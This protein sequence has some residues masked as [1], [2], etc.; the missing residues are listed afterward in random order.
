MRRIRSIALVHETLS[1]AS[2]EEVEFNEIVRPL[3][4]MVEEGLLSPERPVRFTVEGDAG[5]LR[6]EVATPLAVV[7]TELLQNAVEHAFPEDAVGPARRPA[8]A[9][10]DRAT[11]ASELRR[12]GARQRRRACPP[13][14]SVDD[15]TS[16]GLTIVR[17]LVTTELGGHHRDA[18]RRRHARRA[19][20]PGAADRACRSRRPAILAC[21]TV[22]RRRSG[23]RGDPAT[24]RRWRAS[25]ALRSLRRS[26][27][28][29][30]PQ[31][32]ASWLVARANSR[33]AACTSHCRH[34]ALAAAICSMA[35]PV[36]PTGKNRSG[37][38]SRQAAWS[39]QSS[40]S[41]SKGRLQVSATVPPGLGTVVCS[42]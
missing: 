34:T 7:L 29:V 35:G 31:T 12:A 15:A 27:S 25:Q 38:V 17:A 2:G 21:A 22:R 24:T 36:L 19:P 6:A 8:G 37:S 39:R 4:R 26:S 10:H 41:H 42:S 23:R 33:Q 13:G 18:H 5:E 3:V 28:S 32:P 40:V 16:L 1:R 20:H 11:T 14:F 30:P 9:R